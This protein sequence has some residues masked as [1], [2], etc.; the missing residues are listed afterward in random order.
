MRHIWN[1]FVRDLSNATKN[2][3]GIVVLMGLVIVPA[4]YAWF[5]IAGSWDPYGNTKNLKVAVVD[6]DKGYKSGLV[7]VG[8]NAGNTIESTLRANTQ[9]NWQFVDRKTGLDGVYSGKYYAAI[10]IPENFS[11]DM[12]TLFSTHAKRARIVY[13]INEKSNAIAPHITDQGADTIVSQIDATF[14]KT[15]ANIA[16]ELANSVSKYS[17]D[18]NAN[19]Y[20]SN[21]VTNL[22]IMSGNLSNGANQL[23]AYS[24][25]LDSAVDLMDS[26]NSI[27]Q[28]TGQDAGKLSSSIQGMN[29]SVRSVNDALASS[30]AAM[31]KAL[32]ASAA[33]VK[34][35]DSQIDSLASGITSQS[36]AW[37]AEAQ[38]LSQDVSTQAG[39]YDQAA[40]SLQK[41]RDSVNQTATSTTFDDQAKSRLLGRLDA[42]ISQLRTVAQDHRHLSTTLTDTVNAASTVKS[43]A[44]TQKAN[45]KKQVASVAQAIKSAQDDYTNKLKPQLD[46]LAAS[47]SQL[48]T[49]V[50]TVSVDLTSS[51]NGLSKI[52]S[53]TD[54]SM[55]DARKSLDAS[56]KS[57]SNIAGKLDSLATTVRS[58]RSGG[59]LS[60][61]GAG[62]NIDAT[63]LANLFAQPV[64]MKRT[65]VYPVANY[66][67][68]MAPFYTVLAIWVGS[69]ILVAM[70]EAK[71]SDKGKAAVLG[72]GEV[73]ALVGKGKPLRPETPGNMSYF[74]LHLREEY[75]GRYLVFLLLAWAQATLVCMGDL[76]Y[77]RIQC[78]HPWHFFFVG[79]MCAF[80]F[81]NLMY[82]LTV[83]FGAVGKAIAVILL[84]MQV[85]G[86]GG[87][88]PVQMLPQAFQRIYPLF[89]F[90]YAMAAMRDSIAGS[91]GGDF[92]AQMGYLGIFALVALLIGVI[93]RRPFVWLTTWFTH[94]VDS[95]KV[96]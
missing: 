91:Y 78:D 58:A 66:G 8:I 95:T 43:T 54:S 52:N 96:Y 82:A 29:K 71:I 92:W 70:M 39:R 50:S 62:K 40:N 1:I 73:P 37:G 69:V 26:A 56:A 9:L 77:L 53:D 51:L 81:S 21:L 85:A 74:G 67:S 90:T 34:A 88:F 41:L 27:M 46:S 12:M 38:K 23:R 6:K 42:Q 30:S 89:P 83:S 72:L 76:W 19:L 93:L 64:S 86:T 68:Q 65:A 22:T 49:S 17:S 61:L 2:V 24:S 15:I 48:A 3:I 87:T 25:L 31:Q 35:L 4:M 16:L 60:A 7:P 10:I 5:N 47:L 75:F 14:S 63:L 55:A 33:S 44:A 45:L 32:Q 79:W 80:V 36:D 94:Q 18:S 28:E 11:R 57:L 13:Y 84:V 59:L 20:L